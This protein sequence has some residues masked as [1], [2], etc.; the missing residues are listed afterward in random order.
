MS[1]RVKVIRH[2]MLPL[3][4]PEKQDLHEVL[5]SSEKNASKVVVVVVVVGRYESECSSKA[6]S[7][8]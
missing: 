2:G 5:K 1:L 4:K 7:K 8:P 6:F 3:R